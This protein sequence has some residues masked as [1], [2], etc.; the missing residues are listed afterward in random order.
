MSPARGRI[1][2]SVLDLAAA[3]RFAEREL[4]LRADPEAAVA[5]AAYMKTTMPF[6][7]VKTP[8]R[9][10]ITRALGERWPPETASEYRRLVLALWE[11]PHREFKY[12]AIGAARRHRRF[13]TPAAM[14]LYRRLVVE[15]AWWD[16]VDE[17]ASGLAGAVL[18]EDRER[19]T[20]TLRRWLHD[21]DMWLRRSA[22]ISQL[23]HGSATD[24]GFLFECCA[25]RGHETEFFIRKAIGWA[26]RQYAR[27]DPQ[28]V[29]RFVA[30]QSERLSGLSRR[31]AL[32]H[33]G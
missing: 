13:V 18:L 4:R 12:L 28:A 6:F 19:I 22:I 20:P 2:T 27:T 5:M 1:V 21:P 32:K 24:T 15:G 3:I 9:A 11:R 8:N 33:L 26:L 7:G 29:R 10:P 16:L 23:N 14:P 17:V 31:E 30:A 25:A